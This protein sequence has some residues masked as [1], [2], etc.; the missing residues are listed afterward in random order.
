M[1]EDMYGDMSCGTLE[2]LM[3][4]E[5]CIRTIMLERSKLSS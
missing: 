4:V 1:H 5:Q 2:K 3:R